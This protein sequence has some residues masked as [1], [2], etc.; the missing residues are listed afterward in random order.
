MSNLV[1]GALY[2][3]VRPKDIRGF[4]IPLAP[5]SE[6]K[7]IADKL[8]ALLA[9]VDACRERLDRVPLI[10]KRFR[11][12]VLAAAT[13]GK[14]TEEWRE[15]QGLSYE[16]WQRR[17]LG[18]LVQELKNGLS[19]K[20]NKE[21]P[22]T[23]ILRISSV[24][25]FTVNFE[26]LRYL[27]SHIPVES[28]FL[29]TNDL[30]FTRYNGS[31]ELVGVCARVKNLPNHSIVYPDKLIRVK[32]HEEQALPEFIEITANAPSSRNFI[33]ALAKT[34]A[35]QTGISGKDLKSLQVALPNLPEQHEIVRRVETLFAYADRLEARYNAARTQVERL[36]PALLAK[37]FRGELV[38]QDPNDEPASVLLERI[39]AKSVAQPKTKHRQQCS[40]PGWVKEAG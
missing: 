30:L 13:S 18:E 37:A 32:V 4:E 28:Y 36:A 8:D 22:G 40:F 21:P 34:T 19:P 9:R 14:L 20:P 38:P 15:E 26:D 11:Q 7:R 3:A 35:G 2:P 1:Q 24:R 17:S 27:S 6:Q 39:H 12:A 16:R 23:P 31:L 5:L 10:L 29:Q 25:P 33:E